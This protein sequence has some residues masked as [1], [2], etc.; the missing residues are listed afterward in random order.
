[1]S[2]RM[3]HFLVFVVFAVFC[4]SA[5]CSASNKISTLTAALSTSEALKQASDAS[6]AVSVLLTSDKTGALSTTAKTQIA[7]WNAY[8]QLGLAAAGIVSD[9][10]AAAAQTTVTASK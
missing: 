10:V 2:T 5:G 7:Q 4:F 8:A 3:K 1:M 9:A 6:A